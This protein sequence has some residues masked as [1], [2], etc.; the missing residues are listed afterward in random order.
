[1][2]ADVIDFVAYRKARIER[3]E[4][5]RA[6]YHAVIAQMS[7]DLYTA[8]QLPPVDYSAQFIDSHYDTL[9]CDCG[10]YEISYS[11]PG[12]WYGL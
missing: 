3:L 1:M 12:T 4:A 6:A 5:S 7:A 9:P 10:G 11:Y 8:S 2:S